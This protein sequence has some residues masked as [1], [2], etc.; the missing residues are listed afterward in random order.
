[1]TDQVGETPPTAL[2]PLRVAVWNLNH[3]QQPVRPIDTRTAAWQYI[4]DDLRTDVALL[5]ETV[6]PGTSPARRVVY[7][8][9]ADY[10][11]WG[12]AVASFRDDATLEEIW[13]VSTRWDR[14]RRFT[15]AKTFPGSVAVAE[16]AIDGL[17]P[18]TLV[19]V[20][21]VTDVYA[22]TTLLRI[23][24]DL[25]PL[26]DSA[27]G[28]RVIL[29]GDLNMG[30]TTSDPYYVERGNGILGALKSLGLV[31][32]T[33][34]T[35]DRPPSRTDCPC[36]QGGICR[37]LVTWK[38]AAVAPRRRPPSSTSSGGRRR[39]NGASAI[40]AYGMWTSRAY[41]HRVGTRPNCGFRS[42]T[43]VPSRH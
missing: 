19:S 35:D 8:E 10:R 42:T 31:G 27:H 15:L 30:L 22:Q 12:S 7:P 21:A 29:G 40:S 1:M 36:G 18:I 16:L 24:A 9:I 14:R 11:P 5:Q 13:A 39:R 33:E 20:Y 43:A 38:G 17:A 25:I 34:V 4:V 37:H 2:V 28:T 32:A 6:P 3:W 41:R 26:F 23:V